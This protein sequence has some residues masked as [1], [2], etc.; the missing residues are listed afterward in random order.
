MK[1]DFQTVYN[2][3]DYC[4][5]MAAKYEYKSGKYYG[6][7]HKYNEYFESKYWQFRWLM[8]VFERTLK[9]MAEEGVV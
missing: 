5:R 6:V 4:V 1:Y 9:E 8:H 3:Y 7:N 2:M